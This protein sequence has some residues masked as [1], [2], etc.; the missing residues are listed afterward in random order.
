MPHVLLIEDD[1]FTGETLCSMLEAS[2]HT[3]TWARDGKKAMVLLEGGEAFDLV[4]TDILM[5]DM[6]GLESIQYLKRER[7][8]LPVIA[9]TGQVDTP[10]LRAAKLFGAKST[11]NKPFGLKELRGAIE[12]A[13]GS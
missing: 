11:L 5:P 1:P 7:P 12:I 3:V 6:D 4:I 2:G 8:G 10:Y 9:M 13:L